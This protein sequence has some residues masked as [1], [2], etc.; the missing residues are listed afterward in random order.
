MSND[1]NIDALVQKAS[2]ALQERQK[3]MSVQKSEVQQNKAIYELDNVQTVKPDT[4]EIRQYEIYWDWKRDKFTITATYQRLDE[5]NSVAGSYV[6]EFFGDEGHT[7]LTAEEAKELGI[8][9]L[10]AHEWANAWPSHMGEFLLVKDRNES[11]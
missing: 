6:V 11:E 4:Q 8:I 10:S 3:R 7:R 9:M 1:T 2:Q 5:G